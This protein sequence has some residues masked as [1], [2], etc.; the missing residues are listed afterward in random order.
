MVITRSITFGAER[1]G[2]GFAT[3]GVAGDLAVSTR[4][5]EMGEMD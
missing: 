4:G 3:I 1:A 5:G 2:A